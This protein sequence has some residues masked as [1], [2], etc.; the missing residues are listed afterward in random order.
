MS[1]D[2]KIGYCSSLNLYCDKGCKLKEAEKR[3]EKLEN[4]L[5]GENFLDTSIYEEIKKL[6]LEINELKEQISELKQKMR[7]FLKF[8]WDLESEGQT[9]EPPLTFEEKYD[10]HEKLWKELED[11]EKTSELMDIK[12]DKALIK[13]TENELI[14]D[15]FDMF[16][17]IHFS[18]LDYER[19][20]NTSTIDIDELEEVV[21]KPEKEIWE[22]RVKDNG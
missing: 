10:R 11:G 1:E 8:H 9:H 4:C 3:I 17:R 15:V 12:I 2:D 19:I 14:Q 7:K 5:F 22:K 6:Q 21:L 20:A 13:K 16:D 18:L